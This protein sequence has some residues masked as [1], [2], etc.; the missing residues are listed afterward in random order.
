[1]SLSTTL[2]RNQNPSSKSTLY[3]RFFGVKEKRSH[4]KMNEKNRKKAYHVFIDDALAKPK[5]L[6]P[7]HPLRALFN[8]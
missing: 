3:G 4:R 7:K 5:S 2:W 8:F 1:M 6:E